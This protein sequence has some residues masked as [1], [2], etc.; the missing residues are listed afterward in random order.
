MSLGK[1]MYSPK[2]TLQTGCNIL[3]IQLCL[4]TE[5]SV[6]QGNRLIHIQLRS[7]YTL[8]QR[9]IIYYPIY[10]LVYYINTRGN[11]IS[12]YIRQDVRTVEGFIY[13]SIWVLR[14]VNTYQI[15][16][17]YH[18]LWFSLMKYQTMNISIFSISVYHLEFESISN[19][20]VNGN[21]LIFNMV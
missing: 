21:L 2:Y 15:Y 1:F 20:V 13:V 8:G 9:L 14:Y 17:L 4:N 3:F 12:Q 11:A 16:T 5:S 7:T 6:Q 18:A 10:K 19:F